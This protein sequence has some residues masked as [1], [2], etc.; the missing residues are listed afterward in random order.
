M[1][2]WQLVAVAQLR[3]ARWP[4]QMAAPLRC[5]G[6]IAAALAA[7]GRLSACCRQLARPSRASW[8]LQAAQ[9]AKTEPDPPEPAPG[10]SQVAPAASAQSAAGRLCFWRRFWQ[11]NLQVNWPSDWV[12]LWR[13]REPRC[14]GAELLARFLAAKPGATLA[15]SAHRQL[16][17]RQYWKHQFWERQTAGTGARANRTWWTG[18]TPGR[19]RRSPATPW[20]RRSWIPEGRGTPTWRALGVFPD[21]QR[22]FRKSGCH[23][24][25]RICVRS[26]SQNVLATRFQLGRLQG[27]GRMAGIWGRK[28]SLGAT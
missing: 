24:C 14:Q 15:L 8:R 9:V 28:P 6:G 22:F 17:K 25:I 11:L 27:A 5:P 10:Q 13:R 21:C 4:G 23:F 18:Q 7:K 3:A 16:W 26:A 12:E 2:R 20:R 19:R 1:E